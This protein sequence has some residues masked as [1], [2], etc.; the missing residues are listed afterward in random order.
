MPHFLESGKFQLTNDETAT[1][2]AAATRLHEACE[3]GLDLAQPIGID[4]WILI[5]LAHAA[6]AD[7]LGPLDEVIAAVESALRAR[8]RN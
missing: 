5:Q 6:L 1:Y 8:Q 2:R 3:M 7:N 4:D